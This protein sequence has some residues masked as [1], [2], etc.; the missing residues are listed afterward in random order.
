MECSSCYR[1]GLI[2]A[3]AE[4]LIQQWVL[5]KGGRGI[6]DSRPRGYPGGD[7]PSLSKSRAGLAHAT[8]PHPDVVGNATN[9]PNSWGQEKPFG[10]K[11]TRHA[12]PRRR[13]D[14]QGG[15]QFLAGLRE[16]QSRCQKCSARRTGGHRRWGAVEKL[17]RT[18][19]SI[20]RI[21]QWTRVC[22]AKPEQPD[23]CLPSVGSVKSKGYVD[24]RWKP[25]RINT[26]YE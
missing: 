1:A 13:K 19:A 8:N 4:G 24:A 16:L 9:T 2:F 11:R 20:P 26:A 10:A 5:G 18:V 22:T 12:T 17:Q 15:P 21:W 14:H 3:T 7:P 25:G 23:S 6:H